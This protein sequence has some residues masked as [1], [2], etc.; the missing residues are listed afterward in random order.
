MIRSLKAQDVCLRY[1]N[2]GDDSSL[3]LVVYADT[4]H[5]NLLDGGSQG[6]YFIFLVGQNRKCSLLSWKSKKIQ[7]IICSSLAA[8]TS[9][10][11]FG[12]QK[13]L[14]IEVITDNQSLYDALYSWKSISER[15]LRIQFDIGML[16][17]MILRKEIQ[18]VHWVDK[19]HQLAD[20]L[21]KSG[22]SPR[23]IIEIL[24]EGQSP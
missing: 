24:Q 22:A 12:G 10:I 21:S 7:R 1:E 11:Y 2:L 20:V 16:K 13:D 15:W 8:E 17:E 23:K 4:A 14:P 3:K 9:D 18:K 6:G 19:K 5:G